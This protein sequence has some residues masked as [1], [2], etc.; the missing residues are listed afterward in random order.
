MASNIARLKGLD[1]VRV[2]LSLLTRIILALVSI[3]DYSRGRE[4]F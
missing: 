3:F 4:D 1:I 2:M